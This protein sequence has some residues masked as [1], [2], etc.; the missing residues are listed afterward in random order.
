[1][2]HELFER[3]QYLQKYVLMQENFDLVD[4]LLKKDSEYHYWFVFGA[5]SLNHKSDE[6]NNELY[7]L[8]LMSR[9]VCE[10]IYSDKTI[11]WNKEEGLSLTHGKELVFGTDIQSLYMKELE[12]IV[13]PL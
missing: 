6:K 5:R 13:N 8:E 7:I 3:L 2:I 9:N 12:L 4:F 1:M 10:I 11:Y